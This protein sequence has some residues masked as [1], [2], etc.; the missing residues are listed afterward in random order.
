MLWKSKIKVMDWF[1]EVLR[2]RLIP[3]L[4][5]QTN[6]CHIPEGEF[7][8]KGEKFVKVAVTFSQKESVGRSVF[9]RGF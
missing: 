9:R 5:I 1:M 7:S 8:E 2:N 6:Q 3:S 4:K